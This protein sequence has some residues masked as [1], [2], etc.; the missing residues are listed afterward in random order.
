MTTL[1]D[2]FSHKS[3]SPAIIIPDSGPELSYPQLFEQIKK[4]QQQ[5]I[6]K[7]NIEPQEAIAIVLPNSLEFAITFLAITL[8]RN[9]AAPLNPNYAENEFK[10]YINDSKSKVMIVPKGW[11]QQNKPAVQAAKSFNAV[12]FEVAWDNHSQ[13]INLDIKSGNAKGGNFEER[14]P[15]PADVALL[16]HTSGTTGRPKG[17]LIK[18]FYHW[19]IY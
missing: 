18:I 6:K 8:L 14:N 13:Q 4:F 1:A 17:E 15:Y 9:V 2:I 16:L 7:C 3:S 11:V 5:I 12:I 19:L 10:F